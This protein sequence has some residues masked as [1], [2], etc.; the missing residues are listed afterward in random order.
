MAP[1]WRANHVLTAAEYQAEIDTLPGQGFRLLDLNAYSINGV[2]HFATVWEQ[3]SG[4]GWIA[5]HDQT[6]DAH[7]ELFNTLPAQGFRPIVVSGYESAGEARFASL[8]QQV[9]GP[10]FRARH[11]MTGLELQ[12]EFDA[13]PQDFRPVDVSGYT[14]GGEVRFAAIW[15]RSSV[16]EWAARHGM[17]GTQYQQNFEH[18]RDHGLHP[19]RVSGYD[20]GGQ[21]QFA[22]IWIEGPAVTWSSR[23]HLPASQYQAEFQAM[24]GRG[25]RLAKSNGFSSGGQ[26]LYSTIWHKPYL[27]DADELFINNTV[28][29]FMT[30]H[31]VPGGSV[32]LSFQGR[33]VF[34]RGYGVADPATNV[35]VTTGH[36]FRLA[37]LSKPITSVAIFRLIEQGL[38]TLGDRIFGTN[39]LLGT[40]FGTAPYGPNIDQITVQHLLEHTSGWAGN[41]SGAADPM[42]QNFNRNHAELIGDMLDNVPLVTVPGATCDYLNFGYCVLG[43]V[44]EEVTGLTY[45]A[46]VRQHVLAPCGISDMHIAG[47]T[48]GDRRANEVVYVQ[49]GG[50]N[51]YGIRV[52]RMDAHGGWIASATDVVRFLVRVDGFSTKPDI[53]AAGSITTM[54][55]PTTATTPAGGMTGYAKGWAT[56][57]AGNRWHT[58]D[59]AGSITE[60][61]RSSSGFG[62]AALFN[63]RNDAQLNQMRTDIDNLMWTIVGRITDWPPID[64]F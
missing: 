43:R 13:L 31:G 59:F 23:H 10:E 53:L 6:S 51:P 11:G 12:A 58:G 56:N 47:D 1:G 34:A 14:V 49:Q 8:W 52:G 9:G 3:S 22:A 20:V 19:L 54:A 63:S 62:W 28:T 39:S 50:A 5:R 33:L 26:T 48:L 16:R 42:F 38:L 30:T 2:G 4:P 17:T 61:I 32:A 40:T 27:S 57:A 60:L 21:V 37:S 45:E 44:I 24:V 35:P 41:D 64:L 29:N 7:N 25:F 46:A 55:T 36:L 15:E 18:F